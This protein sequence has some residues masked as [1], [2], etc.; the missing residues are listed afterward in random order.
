VVRVG[1]VIKP[2][3]GTVSVN[4]HVVDL[5]GVDAGVGDVVE[6]VSRAGEN[7]IERLAELAGIM[8]YSFCVGLNPL[9]PRIY[10]EGGRPVAISEPRLVE[11]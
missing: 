3:L 7:S 5:D 6:M 4:H 2:V 8:T 9:T 1:G 10:F 11:R